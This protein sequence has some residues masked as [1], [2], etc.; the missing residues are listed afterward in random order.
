M[1]FL[2]DL[3]SMLVDTA[4]SKCNSLDFSVVHICLD[5]LVV[6][7]ASVILFTTQTAHDFTSPTCL[8]GSGI[9]DNKHINTF[10]CTATSLT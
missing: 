3:Y 8:C 7:I 10:S 2:F 4:M 1:V 6:H 5:F 9:E